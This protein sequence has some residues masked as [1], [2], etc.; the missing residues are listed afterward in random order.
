MSE[1]LQKRIEELFE[2]APKTRKTN[3]LKEEL[4][5]NL[6]DKYNDL[7]DSGKGGRGSN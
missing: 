4:L 3:E 5:A 7:V 1:K 2:N 6:I